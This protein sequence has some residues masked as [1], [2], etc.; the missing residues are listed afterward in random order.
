MLCCR[1]VRLL[2]Q[3]QGWHVRRVPAVFLV[4]SLSSGSCWPCAAVPS[5]FSHR[6]TL[7]PAET[8]MPDHRRIPQLLGM[9][10]GDDVSAP[11]TGRATLAVLF[12]HLITDTLRPHRFQRKVLAAG[13]GKPLTIYINPS[14]SWTSRPSYEIHAKSTSRPFA[15]GGSQTLWSPCH[16]G[17]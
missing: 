1:V 16:P 4:L 8:L 5:K 3:A 9:I 14:R 11:T 10:P 13:P 15:R 7:S 6:F 12:H 2:R 17:S